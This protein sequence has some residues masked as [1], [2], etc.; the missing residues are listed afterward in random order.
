[1]RLSREPLDPSEVVVIHGIPCTEVR[2]AVFDEMR[3]TREVREATVAMDMAAAALLTS[4]RRARAY[5]A[6]RRR[7]RR[8]TVVEAALDLASEDSRSPNESR[9]R[10]IWEVDARLPRPLVNQH[11]WDR[12]GNLLGIADLLDVEAGLV[13]EFD[14]ADHR[15][16]TRHTHDIERQGRFERQGLEVFRVTGLDVLKPERVVDRILFHRS[17]ACGLPFEKRHWTI[18]PPRGWEPAQSLD[19]YL[20]ER[21]FLRE[22]HEEYERHPPDLRELRGR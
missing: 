13:G 4:I 18:A 3:R 5:L 6:N 7:W 16:A 19:E 10:L 9:V 15:T 8:S 20:D 22:L 21:D 2:R 17:R 1:M 14:G 12:H 11:V